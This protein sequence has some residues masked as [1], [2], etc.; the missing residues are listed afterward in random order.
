MH[1]DSSARHRNRAPFFGCHLSSGMI[2]RVGMETGGLP[3]SQQKG[4][5]CQCTTA[6]S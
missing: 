1:M 2:V 4:R 6:L 3:G 5:W